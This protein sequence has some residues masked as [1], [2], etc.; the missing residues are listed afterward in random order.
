MSLD[1]TSL[2]AVAIRTKLERGDSS[3]NKV[4]VCHSSGLSAF[5]V[6]AGVPAYKIT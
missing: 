1:T 6:E 4:Q 5:L 2:A 3:I